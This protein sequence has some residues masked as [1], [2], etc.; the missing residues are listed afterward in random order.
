M[1]GRLDSIEPTYDYVDYLN[2]TNTTLVH[3]RAVL[4][5]LSFVKIVTSITHLVINR[6]LDLI[7]SL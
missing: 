3:S 6:N 2:I 5:E 1:K 4:N 7:Y